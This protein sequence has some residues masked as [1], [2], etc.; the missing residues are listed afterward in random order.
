MATAVRIS[1]ER[2]VSSPS[3]SSPDST[4]FRRRA[5]STGS[6]MSS[7]SYFSDTDG[8]NSTWNSILDSPGWHSFCC[9][10]DID[11]A[12]V[13]SIFQCAPYT[14]E[15]EDKMSPGEREGIVLRDFLQACCALHL[16]P[17][18]LSAR[19]VRSAPSKIG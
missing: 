19:Y 16:A 9:S 6:V 10:W 14:L 12:E 2:Q 13:V 11:I 7:G 8:S 15:V 1:R 5:D 18:N 3:F 17:K 4:V